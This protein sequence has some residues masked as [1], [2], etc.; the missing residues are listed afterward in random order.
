MKIKILT[1]AKKTKQIESQSQN[2]HK[3]LKEAYTPEVINSYMEDV[4]DAYHCT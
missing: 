3:P 1:E 2:T 4:Y